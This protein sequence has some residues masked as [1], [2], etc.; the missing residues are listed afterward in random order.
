MD[1]RRWTPA[2]E[3]AINARGG[4]VL[5]AAA[6][7]SGKTAV[8]VERAI[9]RL[10]DPERPIG[11]D[12]LLIVTFTKAAAAEMRSRLEQRLRQLL[13]ETPGDQALRR[14]LLLLDQAVIGTVD[15]FCAG[16]VRERFQLLGV[17][18]DFKILPEKR[19]EEMAQRA[20]EEAV[21][22]AFER[23]TVTDL[24]DAFTGERDDR[25]LMGM[26]RALY[27]FTQS[28][29]F[30]ERWLAE[31]VDLT[32]QG[33][34]TP[35]QR[36]ILDHVGETAAHG[37]ALCAQALRL[38]EEGTPVGDA[39]AE[40]FRAEGRW[41]A[42]LRGLARA[43]DWDGALAALD[44]YAQPAKGR[45]KADE[46]EWPY[47]RLE[48][49][50][51]EVKKETEGLKRVLFATGER[52]AA[53][54]RATAPLL[55][56]LR[57]LT[58]DFSRRYE[59]K[60]RAGDF[61]D[62]S[63]LEHLTIRL[64]LTPEGER[65]PAALEVGARFDEIMIDEYQDINE[66]QDAIFRAVSRQAGNLFMVGD[67]KQS[68]YGFRQAMPEIFLRA[69]RAFP[70]Y[71]R[72]EDR[73]PATVVLDRN[74]RSRESVT[75]SV[76]FVFS[77]LL[78]RETGDLDYTGEERLVP[79]AEYP[80][81]PGTETE[82]AF[83][84]RPAGV[85]APEAEARWIARRLRA[86]RAEGFTVGAGEDRRPLA[87]G[88][89]C[90]LLR[91]ANKYA[92]AYAKE[93]SAF[94]VPAKA[95]ATGGFFAAAEIGVALSLLRVIDNPNQD[96]P[97]L[98]V[99][100]S[101]LYG[102][103][104]DDCARLRARPEDRKLS[105]YA[106]LVR[107]AGEDPRSAGV[108][109]DLSRYRELAATMPADAFLSWLYQATGYPDL[110]RVMENGE[111]RL[112]NLRLL[113][114]A[115]REFESS[116]FH[117]IAG[118]V[119]Y[120]DRLERDGS[121][122]PVAEAAPESADAVSI[123]S[124]HKAKGLEFPVCIVAGCGRD[125]VPEDRAPVL[126]HPTLGLGVK[127]RDARR[128]ARF[129]T[130][131]RE[132]I[133]LADAHS[134][135]A[136]ELRVLYVAMTRAR[137]K[138]ILLASGDRLERSLEKLGMEIGEGPL[139][140]YATRRAKNAG[141]W[142]ALCAL[143]HPDGAA[144][145]AL[146]G[147][148]EEGVVREEYTPWRVTL[149]EAECSPAEA[150]APPAREPAAPDLELL[151]RMEAR[152]A[153]RYPYER[154]LGIPAKVAAS[155]LAE[156][157]GG[158]PEALSRPAWMG[159]RG[160]TPAERGTALHECMRFMDL[161]RAA[162]DPAGEV[163]RLAAEGTL[164][165]EQADAVDPRR[166]TDFLESD[167]GKRVLASPHVERERRFTAGIPAA[168]ADPTLPATDETVILQGAADCVFEEEGRLRIIDFK[169]DRA[170]SMEALWARY[171]PQ[172]ELYGAAMEAV[173]GQPVDEL[174]LWS[175]HLGKSEGRKFRN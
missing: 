164:T 67:V 6:A 66:A 71:D 138:L 144:L 9:R 116:G 44:A 173:T 5:V 41:L 83:L 37:E 60:K 30:P 160:M 113:E 35:W 100:M 140:P 106:S 91:S 109:E 87:W 7:G 95:A 93:L 114:S 143:R 57:E 26:V 43:G 80:D 68:I 22:A 155:K 47:D 122:L 73:Y 118:F 152:A 107:A 23:G 172:L 74:F 96:I 117:G 105:L 121:D 27:R 97:L 149:E 18:P 135:A 168:L 171:A 21:S 54:L 169:T 15:S 167:L 108:L 65:T 12:R 11:A 162:Q 104:P 46:K 3:D 115:A 24:A 166:I 163:A 76:N 82:V 58:L 90:I 124:V 128:S 153:Y 102:F 29:P 61:L 34:P 13:R 17:P 85:E 8:L 101:P 145:R 99:L 147:L 156:E 120:L 42:G 2:Q 134:A 157:R 28:H 40:A 129:T 103:S 136:E 49:A 111:D 16:M 52:C 88:D 137:E 79:G 53:E 126:L 133:A 33:D 159:E 48:A 81:Q 31:M 19:E 36:V 112:R 77:Q 51:Q 45:L 123:M 158:A 55:A 75:R 89:V 151:R 50:R 165:P 69:R 70:R 130:T 63:D 132:A 110:A 84:S 59:E 1:E 39:F 127:L 161:R 141:Q 86:L 98:A 32:A 62:Y 139:S 146:A 64:F 131:A 175:T 142:L 119:R 150:P 92:H 20:L 14:Q 38:A 154:E 10:T 78:S 174:I 170:A 72:R 94:G 4:T 56:S 148:G 25:R 125:F